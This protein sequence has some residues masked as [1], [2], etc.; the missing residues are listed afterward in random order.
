MKLSRFGDI[1][2][3][4]SSSHVEIAIWSNKRIRLDVSRSN[5]VL[6]VLDEKGVKSMYDLL[7]L[8]ISYINLK[9]CLINKFTIPRSTH[10][11]AIVQPD[12]LGDRRTSQMLRDMRTSLPDIIYDAVL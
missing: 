12:S 3:A 9:E 2:L 4:I 6:F 5:R 10:F 1:L 8:I 7:G 11:H